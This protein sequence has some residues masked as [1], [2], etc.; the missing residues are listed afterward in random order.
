VDY[1]A[2]LKAEP[3]SRLGTGKFLGVLD[4]APVLAER[5]NKSAQIPKDF[6]AMADRDQETAA[7]HGLPMRA[8]IQN[9][10]RIVG[11]GPGWVERLRAAYARGACLPVAIAI[12]TALGPGAAAQNDDSRSN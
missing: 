4:Q 6:L 12:L 10:R 7:A 2:E 11:D 5:L 8:D 1:S 9:I 3:G